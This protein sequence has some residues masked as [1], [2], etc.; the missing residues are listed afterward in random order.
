MRDMRL[1]LIGPPG[2]GKGTQAKLLSDKFGLSHFSTGDILR[3]AMRLA[4]AAGKQAA[5]YLTT[6]RLVPDD[7]VNEMVAEL[8]RTQR[9][10]KFVMDGYPR[11]L[12]QAAS[13]DQ[14]LRQ[15]FLDLTAAVVLLVPDQEIIRRLSGRRFCPKCQATF[16]IAF[17]PP[18]VPEYC[19]ECGNK[20]AQRDDDREETIRKRLQIYH[21]NTTAL[22]GHYQAQGLLREV[23]GTGTPDQVFTQIAG[24]S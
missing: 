12:A 15:Q 6:G 10:E 2:S 13:F 5:P 22:L 3:E 14:V 8:F 1:I 16:H 20:L 4:T 24:L 21:Q 7:L 18:R 9:P 23:D 19:D 11:T 17:R